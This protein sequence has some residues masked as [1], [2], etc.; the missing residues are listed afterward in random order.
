[1]TI[2][3]II[4]VSQ[5]NVLAFE[6]Y[7]NTLAKQT[8]NSKNN[9]A[10]FSSWNEY[11]KKIDKII[12]RIKNNK[13][14]LDKLEKK[15]Y[16]LEKKLASK[17]Q[18]ARTKKIMAILWYMKS[19]VI[20]EIYRIEKIQAQVKQKQVN[21]KLEEMKTSSLSQREKENVEKEIVKVQLSLLE[22]TNDIINSLVQDF[23]KLLNYEAKGDFKFNFNIDHES[24][25]KIKTNLELNN[26]SSKAS[27]FDSQL[28]WQLKA[29]VEA[30]PKWE[31]SIKFQMESFIDFISKKGNIYLLMN[32]LN[33]TD[34]IWV[35]SIKREIENLKKV[36]KENKYI[37]FED[38]NTARLISILDSINTTKILADSKK[39]MSK[40]MFKAYKKDGNKYLLAPTKYSCDKIKEMSARFDPWGGSK[41]SE[42]QYE[43]MLKA[44]ANNWELYMEMWTSKNKLWLNLKS[45]EVK[46]FNSYIIF[47]NES[48]DELKSELITKD[49][50]WFLLEYVK[51]SRLDFNLDDWTNSQIKFNAKLDN[52][53]KFTYIDSKLKLKWHKNEFD[54]NLKLE[55]K[56]INWDFV[57]K[58]EKYDGYDYKTK[59]SKYKP[60]DKIEWKISWE[61]D[62]NGDIQN[63]D[64]EMSWTNLSNNEKFL[65]ARLTKKND[66]YTA[67]IKVSDNKK[68]IIDI[69]TKIQN[70]IISGTT[71][72]FDQNWKEYLKITHSW[73]YEK[74][75][76]EFNNKIDLSENPINSIY[77][78][79]TEKARDLTRRSDLRSLQGAIEQSYQDEQ[80]YPSKEN[81]EKL[82][83]S[84]LW[85]IPK[86]PSWNIEINWCKF[87]YTY[88]VWDD[89]NWIKNQKYRISSCVENSDNYQAR[90]DKW[91]DN[92]KIELWIDIWSN[93]FKEK[94]Y[95]NWYK[96]WTK[97][98]IKS[99]DVKAEIN[100]NILVDTKNNK[101]NSNL[102]IDYIEWKNKILEIKMQNKWT[103]EYKQTEIKA[104][105][106]TMT[107]Q[108]LMTQ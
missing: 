12:E 75:Y 71:K 83:S 31:D 105:N 3:L 61:Q 58:N 38:K 84:Y 10:K 88:E 25:W 37:K 20:V 103:I 15:I 23:E 85:K 72:V 96:T 8:V 21:Q 4:F 17:T 62:Y 101:N 66:D 44:L 80:E 92:K 76:L 52:K 70:K 29:L 57:Y 93:N 36:A 51:N 27:W 107:I 30:V 1:M 78:K 102:Y 50:E 98:E 60:W 56:K 16:E 24:I 55:N 39:A 74:D 22:N 43:D 104:P 2:I 63:I 97:K 49:N 86:D 87:W 5:P 45:N 26:Y 19:K 28:S 77:L 6:S 53:N 7:E 82:L 67:K 95:I 94:F 90:T 13:K 40:P 106:N 14:I 9:L 46:I 69:N 99:K 42:S 34:E 68:E 35:K 73:K 91:I 64:L 65:E 47:T 11:I 89:K 41:C 48:V 79:Q 81:F 32:K 108:E 33:I 54:A 18:N 59:K 100:L